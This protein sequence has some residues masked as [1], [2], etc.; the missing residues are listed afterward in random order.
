MNLG[1]IF[2]DCT[3]SFD[4]KLHATQQSPPLSHAYERCLSILTHH[5]HASYAWNPAARTPTGSLHPFPRARA[6][7]SHNN[8]KNTPSRHTSSRQ[9]ES[10]D[11]WAAGSF[12]EARGAFSADKSGTMA[13]G[14]PGHS[15]TRDKI[16]GNRYNSR[17]ARLTA[18]SRRRAR[19]TEIVEER[20]LRCLHPWIVTLLARSAVQFVPSVPHKHRYG[21]GA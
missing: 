9:R 13:G 6:G 2:Q 19:L 10:P 3:V 12:P 20:T 5:C 15:V 1:G 21:L 8:H 4:F 17:R 7:F 18:E 16:A 14:S 11:T